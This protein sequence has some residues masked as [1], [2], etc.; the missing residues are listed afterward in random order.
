M[1]HTYECPVRWAD[2]DLFQHVNNVSYADYLQEARIDMFGAHPEFAGGEELADGVVVV[3]HELDF[4][5][6]MSFRRRSV[7]VDSWVTEIRAGSFTAAYE[8]YD[9][10]DEGRRTYLRASTR[11]APMVLAT[12][13][14]RRIA[15]AERGVLEHYLEPAEPRQQLVSA[16]ESRHVYPLTVR[17]S[18]LDPYQHVNNVKYVEY[19]QE[20]RISYSMSMH[21]PGDTFGQFVVARTDIDY[22]RPVTFRRAPYEI[23]SWISHVGRTSAIFAA[24][25]RDGD[26]VLASARAVTV[27]FDPATQRS[28]PVPADHHRRLTEQLSLPAN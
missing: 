24:E 1:R 19:F 10:T 7:L 3:R 13:A 16:G 25:L 6:P 12:G 4:V 22:R 23:H 5:A 9:E 15:A 11:L 14:P 17:W 8:V 2:L 21:Q 26:E 28:A 27:G 18:D 20:A